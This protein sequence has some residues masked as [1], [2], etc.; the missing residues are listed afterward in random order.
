M[1]L[2]LPKVIGL[3]MVLLAK[4]KLLVAVQAVSLIIL[5]IGHLVVVAILILPANFRLLLKTKRVVSCRRRARRFMTRLRRWTVK[6]RVFLFRSGRRFLV[7]L[8]VSR[9]LRGTFFSMRMLSFLIVVACRMSSLRSLFLIVRSRRMFRSFIVLRFLSSG[10]VIHIMITRIRRVRM[11]IIVGRPR[12]FR[13]RL[14][15]RTPVVFAIRRPKQ[16]V[17]GSSWRII[18]R[19]VLL[20]FRLSSIRKGKL[21]RSLLRRSR[22]VHRRLRSFVKLL[23]LWR[24]F[25][26]LRFTTFRIL[27]RR[28]FLFH[29]SLMRRHRIR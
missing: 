8:V 23:V 14:V 29:L 11:V 16:M 21:L 15:T 1:P 13:L 2:I 28:R 3:I 26:W 10:M 18:F 12:L 25:W 5:L 20:F 17:F 7:R 19:M 24:M 4:L 6:F 9:P 22:I 27:L